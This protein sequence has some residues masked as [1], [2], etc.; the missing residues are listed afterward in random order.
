MLPELQMFDHLPQAVV[1]LDRV[2]GGRFAYRWLNEATTQQFGIRL[3]TIFGKTPAEAFPG[4]AGE[5]LAARQMGAASDGRVRTY[6][7]PLLL[8]KGEV[9]IST[10]LSPV[11]GPS[12]RVDRLIA[13]MRDI[14]AERAVA[15]QNANTQAE[16][17]VLGHEIEHFL[18]IAAH[19]LRT[20]MRHVHQIAQMLRDGFV[21]RGDG[22]LELIDLL[23]EVGAKSSSLISDILAYA[24]ATQSP[25]R[26]GRVS[27]AALAE[28]IFAILDPW[29]R[30]QLSTE[31]VWVETDDIALQIALRNLIDNGLKHSGGDLA[32]VSVHH[33]ADAHGLVEFAVIDRGQGFDG[34]ALRFLQ[35][36][37]FRYDSGYGLL[38]VRR[39]I[40]ARG[41]AMWVAETKSG[42]T[43]GANVH[44][45][46]PGEVLAVGGAEML[47]AMLQ[48]PAGR[49]SGG[50]AAAIFAP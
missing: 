48:D 35:E 26:V 40:E 41:G 20:P 13:T 37:E 7:Y 11:R 47:D 5:R 14:T 34:A 45:T 10:H 33:I 49:S 36:G 27:L 8:P 4:R 21:D 46:L 22:K 28:D 6:E 18:T 32:Q 9:W 30:H 3:E 24:C 29:R 12:G 2:D 19:D 50:A 15:T 16:L 44:F 1:V 38:G 39:M 23:E 43:S 17:R 42:Q 25:E 31:D